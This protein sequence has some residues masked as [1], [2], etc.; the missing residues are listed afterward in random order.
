MV[1]I[2][3]T[4]ST[5]YL[6]K[7]DTFFLFR[8]KHLN[9]D[10]KTRDLKQWSNQ[11]DFHFSVRILLALEKVF[12][13]ELNCKGTCKGNEGLVSCIILFK[14]EMHFLYLKVR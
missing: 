11:V 5:F 13:L 10:V 3:K 6:K 4:D 7:R 9:F 2:R 8:K 12:R 1:S 14:R